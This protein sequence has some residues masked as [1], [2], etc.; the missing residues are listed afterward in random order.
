[1]SVPRR[2]FNCKSFHATLNA[3]TISF[4]DISFPA[5]FVLYYFSSST[6]SI[7]LTT[8]TQNVCHL[9]QH[10]KHLHF[11]FTTYSNKTNTYPSYRERYN[12]H[13]YYFFCKFNDCNYWFQ[14]Y[15]IQP[16]GILSRDPKIPYN[17]RTINFPRKISQSRDFPGN[18]ILY[19]LI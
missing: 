4:P 14:Y 15:S 8:L 6:Y 12:K 9:Q 10:E 18:L 13:G 5:Q 7:F 11:A 2:S 3:G 19:L 1:M 16:L 17:F